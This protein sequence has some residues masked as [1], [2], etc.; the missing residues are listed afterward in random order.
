MTSVADADRAGVCEE[1]AQSSPGGRLR[2]PPGDSAG[3]CLALLQA[4][5]FP[6]ELLIALKTIMS[7]RSDLT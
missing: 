7:V 6:L 5:S 2:S 1:L 3:P 4:G